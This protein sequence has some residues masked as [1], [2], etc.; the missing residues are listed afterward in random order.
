MKLREIFFSF[1]VDKLLDRRVSVS[2]IA[3]AEDLV[4]SNASLKNIKRGIKKIRKEVGLDDID[5]ND[6]KKNKA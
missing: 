6:D 2:K 5:E 3:K 1:L 4:L